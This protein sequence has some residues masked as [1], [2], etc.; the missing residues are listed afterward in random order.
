MSR[1]AFERSIRLSLAVRHWAVTA[2][3][4]GGAVVFVTHHLP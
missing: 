2:W 4:V 1:R 3:I